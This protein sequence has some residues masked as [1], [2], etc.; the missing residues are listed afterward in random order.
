MHKT[1]AHHRCFFLF[2][3]YVVSHKNL[4]DYVRKNS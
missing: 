3:Y 1:P 4:A 2:A